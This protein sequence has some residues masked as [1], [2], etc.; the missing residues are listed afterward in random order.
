MHLPYGHVALASET[1]EQVC[2]CTYR[3][4]NYVYMP[5][6]FLCFQRQNEWFPHF[7]STSNLTSSQQSAVL[8]HAFAQSSRDRLGPADASAIPSFSD[9]GAKAATA[10]AAG[11]AAAAGFHVLQT[12][13]Q[14]FEGGRYS[15]TT[16][17]KLKH[18]I[19]QLEHIA[20]MWPGSTREWL[21]SEVLPCYRKVFFIFVSS[22]SL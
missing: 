17:Y 21:N 10:A 9:V 19:E 14:E 22:N 13:M 6:L 1:I 11:E 8:A 12:A 3:M 15:Y 4:L 16:R 5:P 7:V 2:I 20:H 18:D